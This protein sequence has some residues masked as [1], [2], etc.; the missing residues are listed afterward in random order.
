INT[1]VQKELLD[2]LISTFIQLDDDNLNSRIKK[3]FESQEMNTYIQRKHNDIFINVCN[4]SDQQEVSKIRSAIHKAKKIYT[5]QFQHAASKLF[6]SNKKEYN[7]KFVK[8]ATDISNI[9]QTSIYTTVE[10][11]KAIYQFLTREM[12]QHWIKSMTLS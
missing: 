7:A 11:T 4:L 12:P 8:L 10:C 5:A 2:Q 3:I 6:K 1:C 9:G